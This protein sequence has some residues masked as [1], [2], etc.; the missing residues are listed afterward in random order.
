MSTA[1]HQQPGAQLSLGWALG[2][3]PK[4][5]KTK[6][7]EQN[8]FADKIKLNFFKTK[9]DKQFIVDAMLLIHQHVNFSPLQGWVANL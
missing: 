2:L 1:T 8:E 7:T 5:N 3:R 6:S 4:Y 9:V